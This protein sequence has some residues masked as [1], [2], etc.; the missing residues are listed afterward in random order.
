MSKVIST[1]T[2]PVL[3]RRALFVTAG[4]ATAVLPAACTLVPA[5]AEPVLSGTALLDRYATWL[6]HERV[7]L[8]SARYED[9]GYSGRPPLMWR[10]NDEVAE[11]FVRDGGDVRIRAA[12]VLASLKLDR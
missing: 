12:A 1:L 5:I 8:L 7:A 11:A 4:A 3:T 10:G 9:L 6:W 2:S